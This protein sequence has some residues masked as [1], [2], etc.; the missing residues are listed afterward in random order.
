V[1]AGEASKL[2]PKGGTA[3]GTWLRTEKGIDPNERRLVEDWQA[4]LEEFA[5]RPIHGHRRGPSGGNHRA[6]RKR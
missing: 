1:Q 3:F 2:F 5:A 6:P 4:L